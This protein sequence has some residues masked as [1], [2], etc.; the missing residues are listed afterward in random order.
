MAYAHTF[1]KLTFG[2]RLAEGEE[3]WSCGIHL[4]GISVNVS[5]Q[6]VNDITEGEWTAVVNAVK[7]YV[8]SSDTAVP[9]AVTLN[10]VKMA[11]IGTNGRYLGGPRE[12]NDE[13]GVT[14]GASA[15]YIPQISYVVTLVAD[16]FKDPG[17]YNRFY[18]PCA[19]PTGAGTYKMT[20]PI[21]QQR[22]NSAKTLVNA[23]N[24]TLNASDADLEVAI[25][26]EKVSSYLPAE[27]VQ[28]G[29][30]YDTQRRRRNGLYEDYSK[31][32]L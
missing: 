7:A 20:A 2:G 32:S 14:G 11:A 24:T 30:L 13:T 22:A 3:I 15:A 28:V 23:L 29:T 8:S 12:W 6:T 4:D 26:S 1:V 10:W 5:E 27:T 9:S 19:A 16:K 25:V 17:K 31:V 21:A 18:V